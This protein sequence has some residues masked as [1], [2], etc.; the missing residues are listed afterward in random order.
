M[1]K[2]IIDGEEIMVTQKD[3]D[4]MNNHATPLGYHV[5]K[6][7]K[8][9]H[10]TPPKIGLNPKTGTIHVNN[11]RFRFDIMDQYDQLVNS[12]GLDAVF[13]IKVTDIIA[14]MPGLLLDIM[15]KV[16]DEVEA[17]SSMLILEAMKME[18]V[19]KAEGTGIVK[20]INFEVGAT[21]DK[22]VVIIEME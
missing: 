3:I 19:I 1:Y 14:P 11:K 8:A 18:N 21:V 12:M 4:T 17:G 5:L 10:V 7:N 16:G 9:Y 6:E 2:V 13:E 22:G 20:S 15:V